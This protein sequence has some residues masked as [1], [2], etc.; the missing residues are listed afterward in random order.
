MWSLTNEIPPCQSVGPP[1]SVCTCSLAL[2]KEGGREGGREEGGGG[3]GGRKRGRKGERE[4]GRE[5]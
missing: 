3:E 5:G 1:Q 4:R 2:A